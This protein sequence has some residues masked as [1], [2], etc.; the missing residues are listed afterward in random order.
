M[1]ALSL[2]YDTPITSLCNF[3]GVSYKV[4]DGEGDTF[5]YTPPPPSPPPPLS[6]LP[7]LPLP[8]YT[9][10]HKCTPTGV[11]ARH[12]PLPRPRFRWNSLT[13]TG[14]FQS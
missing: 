10:T 12:F 13:P 6:P 14:I 5:I 2:S 11:I 7:P 8:F 3:R 9:K 1:I 4:N